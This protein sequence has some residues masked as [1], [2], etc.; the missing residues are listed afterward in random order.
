MKATSLSVCVETCAALASDTRKHLT[1]SWSK[2][3]E[4]HLPILLAVDINFPNGSGGYS[5]AT[6]SRGGYERK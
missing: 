5:R 4:H 1:D 6:R 3:V 2:A